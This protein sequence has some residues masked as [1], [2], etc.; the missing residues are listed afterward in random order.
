MKQDDV[1][2]NARACIGMAKSACMK[3]HTGVEKS[4]ARAGRS[5]IK[6]AK[7]LSP[8]SDSDW[9]HISP[10]NKRYMADKLRKAMVDAQKAMK[11]LKN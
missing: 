6:L 7:S 5:S 8:D 10:V 2:D 9:E 1:W 11:E 4:A 3:G